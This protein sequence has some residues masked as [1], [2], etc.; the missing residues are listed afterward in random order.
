MANNP[1]QIEFVDHRT[2]EHTYF[3]ERRVTPARK[4][5]GNPLIEDCHSAQTVLPD[6]EG[7]LRMWYLTRRR[8][9]GH[10]G[11]GRQYTLHY[12][13]SADGVQWELPSLGL[14]E[15][16]GGRDNNVL[17][18]VDDLFSD[19]ESADESKGVWNFCVIDNHADDAPHAR[20]R[21]TALIGDRH[22]AWSDD[23]L[24]WTM[25]PENP[26]F[27]PG[28]S[29][30]FNNF[31][32][33][34]RIGRYVLYHRPHPRI[35]AGDWRQV[36]RLVARI[37]S[38]DLI[39]WDWSSARCVLDTDARDAPAVGFAKERRGR[40][41][42]FYSMTVAK[43]GELYLGFAQTLDERTGVMDQRL[44]RSVDGIDWRR[45]ALDTPILASSAPGAWDSGMTGFIS[46]GC[47][48]EFN[49]K[50]HLYYG[51]MNFTHSYQI[52]TADPSPRMSLGLATVPVGRLVGYHAG[53]EA[54]QLMTRPFTLQSDDLRLNASASAGEVTAALVHADGSPVPGCETDKANPIRGDGPDLPLTWAGDPDLASLEGRDVRLRITATNAALFAIS[55]V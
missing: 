8:I 34:A 23:G 40:D 53:V 51:G 28:G 41:V 37:E 11:S 29:D 54:G 19:S 39:H 33:D 15:V 7:G 32:Y 44:V 2:V 18:T 5:V 30:T 38:D 36:N 26:V 4:H 48:L 43:H 50:L 49:G 14:K 42:Q 17:M 9:P 27:D 10:T 20:G 16:D 46:S 3:L 35:R 25:Y 1:M 55:M 21:Y 22:F 12:A 13:E 47:P 45:E 31:H 6:G 52:M 24:R